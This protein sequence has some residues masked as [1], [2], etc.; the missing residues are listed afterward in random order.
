MQI[1][2]GDVMRG[3]SDHTIGHRR[4][5]VAIV[6]TM[7]ATS[8][9]A[10]G[11]GGESARASGE[12]VGLVPARLLETRT[13][14]G[15]A[16]ID[17]QQLGTGALGPAA[18][19]DLPILGRGGVPAGGVG[20]VALNVTAIN[21]SADSFITIF[22]AGTQQPTAS[23]LNTA[24]GRTVPNMVIVALGQGPGDTAGRI[25]IFN[26]AGSVDLAVDVLGWFPTGG[27]F[28]GLLP[29][30][31][32]ETRS[33][34]GLATIDGQQLG[35]GPLGAAAT[36][37]LAM[38][39]RG[40]VPATGAG[41]VALNVTAINPN[42]DSFITV[43]PA[44]APRPT[45]S[46]LNTAPG[47]TLPN[48]VIVPLGSNG[49]ISLFNNAG[50]V[51][52]AVDV[53]GWFAEGGSFTGVV[54]ARALETRVGPGFTTVDGQHAGV[55]PLGAAASRDVPL[56]GRGGVP[57]TG[58]GAVAL[59]V[60]AINPSSDSF[61][62]VYPAGAPRPTA[63]NLNTAPGRTLPNMVIV[64]LGTD[65]AG[66]I[67][68]FNNAGTVDIAVDVLGW[69]ASTDSTGGP[70]TTTTGT[71][72]SSTDP[73]AS[74]TT[75][76]PA[77]TTSST[78][79]TTTTTLPPIPASTS[80]L[81]PA[82]D[83]RAHGGVS[84][85]PR[86]SRDGNFVAFTS[87]A[88]N[89]V[90]GDTNGVTDVFVVE[91]ATGAIDRVSVAADGS[92]LSGGSSQPAISDNGR[93]VAFATAVAAVAGD[94]NGLVDVYRRDRQT[95]TTIL[96]S[97]RVNGSQFNVSADGGEI[98][99]DGNVIAFIGVDFDGFGDPSQS[100]FVRDVAAS[101]TVLT[102]IATAGFDSGSASSTSI[103]QD[104]DKIAVVK[105]LSAAQIVFHV[106]IFDRSSTTL[107]KLTPG[108][109]TAADQG[110]TSP[111][112]SDDG[113]AAVYVRGFDI[114]QFVQSGTEQ[115][116]D[117]GVGG[118]EA[119]GN[120]FSARFAG[121]TRNIIFRSAA[122]NLVASD[123]NG[124]DDIF[125][126]TTTGSPT[127]TLLSVKTKAGFP[128]TPANGGSISPSMSADGTRLV[129]MS[130]ATNLAAFADNGS[131]NMMLRE[132]SSNYRL[133]DLAASTVSAHG[134]STNPSI[135]P[136]GRFVAFDSRA[137]DLIKGGDGN[138]SLDTFLL[139]RQS[140]TIE[141]VSLTT[142]GGQSPNGGFSGDVSD[143]GNR[144]VFVSSS[145]LTGVDSHGATEAYVRDRT[146]GTTTLAS[147]AATGAL[148]ALPAGEV[149]ISGNGRF[150]VFTSLASNLISGDTNNRV[151]V[152]VRDVQT[153]V[154][155]R[156]NLSSTGTEATGALNS[157]I[158]LN[159]SVSADGRFVT[160][161]STATNLVPG[162]T[163]AVV[164]VYVRDRQAATTTLVAAGSAAGI[165]DDGRFVAL[166]SFSPLVAGDTNGKA[167]VFVADVSAVT[168]TRVS[169]A[170][171]GVEANDNSAS[172]SISPNGRFVSFTSAASNLVDG[173]TNGTTDAFVHDR[174]DHTTVRVSVQSGGE[175]G[176]GDT[177][178]TST[179]VS[180]DGRLVA[181]DSGATDLVPGDVNESFDIFLR[182]VGTA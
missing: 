34:P 130:T 122:S 124:A 1:T 60:T 19:R 11:V 173:D 109:G 49:Q 7:I 100:S 44:G 171:S 151:D 8:L 51:D 143:D 3:A 42:T 103:S 101:T 177:F 146:A 59:N 156:V 26:N 29:A 72:P 2:K 181:F 179:S 136:D 62:T 174:L 36:I 78:A 175:Q 135:S 180:A 170:D 41:A 139:D 164:R 165:S 75:T 178:G 40:G 67:T 46:N 13:G 10:I 14:P 24:P 132:G 6:A 96:V 32:L 91:I 73:G 169:V 119:N 154:T 4:R 134:D 145:N 142:Q 113:A 80:L 52:I 47:R 131:L 166:T 81:T 168:I 9:I 107:T 30:R 158:F 126:R 133:L 87:L 48:M 83:D 138:Q 70:T 28:T 18:S 167:D 33:G 176:V 112:L 159:P 161:S 56:L 97:L 74:T 82:I 114:Y 95:D 120:A 90:P 84:E 16:T 22:P 111:V 5:V 76:D 39:G 104:G 12:F 140:Q 125:L 92:Q 54:P 150:V 43:Y 37:D 117:V 110:G 27:S 89:L 123:T 86:I 163:T 148:S 98:S 153:G 57:S 121:N 53:L 69:F 172:V 116:I 99:G 182:D 71:A 20:A 88:S 21:P 162:A 147:P 128:P 141:R 64:P 102:S 129:M 31:V 118:A 93:F 108:G 137:A 25:T 94:T 144:I 23:N 77:A 15:F 55:G 105:R 17:G 85:T 68:I 66:S 65:T 157:Q 45:A 115:R 63:S 155:E 35:A 160:F 149:A 50:T 79:A 127:T 152:F 58:V 106:F 38:A 61:I